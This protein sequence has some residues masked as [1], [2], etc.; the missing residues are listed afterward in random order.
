MSSNIVKVIKIDMIEQ[1]DNEDG[2]ITTTIVMDEEEQAKIQVQPDK[3]LSKISCE[4]QKIIKVDITGE[5][6]NGNGTLTTTLVM[7]E[8]KPKFMPVPVKDFKYGLPVWAK[9]NY[10]KFWPGIIDVPQKGM[11]Q[12]PWLTGVKKQVVYF[13][14]F[15]DYLWVDERNIIPYQGIH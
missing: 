6:D 8:K 7:E 15:L 11:V 1:V 12:R 5:I 10:F 9:V 2:T 4:E 14:G 3:D 13:F